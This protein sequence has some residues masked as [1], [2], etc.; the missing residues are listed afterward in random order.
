MNDIAKTVNFSGRVQGVGFRY[1]AQRIANRYELAGYVKNMPDG[2]VEMLLQGPGEDI[3]QCLDDIG[4]TF[5][6]YI[7]DRRVNKVPVN[8]KYSSDFEIAF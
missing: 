7:R 2:S 3:D 4:E 5:G 1:T 6:G 8:D